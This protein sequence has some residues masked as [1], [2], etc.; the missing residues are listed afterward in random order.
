MPYIEW[1]Q[2]LMVGHKDIDGDHR[3]LVD[4]VNRLHDAMKSGKSKDVLGAVLGSLIEYTKNHFAMEET[5]MA[6][7]SY[8]ALAD[9]RKEHA[10]LLKKADDLR[11]RFGKGEVM[12]GLDTM[13]FL[14]DWLSEHI[15]NSDRKLS[16]YVAK[17]A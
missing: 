9:H 11:Q 5:L 7:V 4:L 16:A 2:K 14:R 17:A 3:K 8:P 10:D 15:M 13:N 12:I 1:S 6:K